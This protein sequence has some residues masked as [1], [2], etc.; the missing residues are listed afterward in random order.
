MVMP[1]GR[2]PTLTVFTTCI[3]AVSTT[4]IVLSF[5]LET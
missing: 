4:V 5:S 3:V 2:C 1:R